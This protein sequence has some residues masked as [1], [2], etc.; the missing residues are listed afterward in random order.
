MGLE[1]FSLDFGRYIDM[2]FHRDRYF[3]LITIMGIINIDLFYDHNTAFIQNM[4]EKVRV[5]GKV[6]GDFPH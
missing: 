2:S 6:P 4:V 1:N 5:K 3:L